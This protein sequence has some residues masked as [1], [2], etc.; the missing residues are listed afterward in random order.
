MYNS[1]VL[2]IQQCTYIWIVTDKIDEECLKRGKDTAGYYNGVIVGVGVPDN[3]AVRRGRLHNNSNINISGQVL[4]YC[5]TVTRNFMH[6][7]DIEPSRYVYLNELLSG[8]IWYAFEGLHQGNDGNNF[9]GGFLSRE[10]FIE[11]NCVPHVDVLNANIHHIFGINPALF[12]K[13]LVSCYGD[14]R[15][16]RH[17]RGMIVQSLN[18]S[19]INYIWKVIRCNEHFDHYTPLWRR[20]YAMIGPPGTAERN[21]VIC[22]V[23]ATYS[24]WTTEEHRSSYLKT[25]NGKGEITDP[26]QDDQEMIITIWLTMCNGFNCRKVF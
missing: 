20:M 21:R 25:C 5:G 7:A 1:D 16:D 17:A 8:R 2:H 23:A 12:Q 10:L 9:A 15:D 24:W 3:G 14:E 13:Y 19:Q 26:V 11:T 4:S 22:I 6:L 18:A